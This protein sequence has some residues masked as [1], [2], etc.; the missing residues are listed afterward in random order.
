MSPEA[1]LAGRGA[2]TQI[3]LPQD[4]ASATQLQRRSASAALFLAPMLQRLTKRAAIH[5]AADRISAGTTEW[6]PG[7]EEPAAAST[8]SRCKASPAA[9][10]ECGAYI[11]PHRV[12]QQTGEHA[13][14]GDGCQRNSQKVEDD[15]DQC[16][17]AQSC[18]R[19]R[20]GGQRS[21]D[22]RA[23]RPPPYR[24][25]KCPVGPFAEGRGTP[26]CG[27]REPR[28]QIDHCP[29]ID[30]KD[31]EAGCRKK[32][33]GLDSSLTYPAQRQKH[34]ECGRPRGRSRPA[35]ERHVADAGAGRHASA[36]PCSG[37]ARQSRKTQ[38]VITPTWKPEIEKR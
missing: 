21:S 35:Q 20:R 31:T 8:S 6:P 13:G 37:V 5:G 25:A 17:R 16:D 15:A 28:A 36:R 7:T 14:Y 19:N 22:G 10:G 18:C 27:C 4:T 34:R 32:G 38:A 23:Q 33:V 29:W 1:L 2:Q 26:Q 9:A 24:G 12:D 30:N 3:R 11:G